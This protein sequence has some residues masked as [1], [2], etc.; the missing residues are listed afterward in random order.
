[1]RY[2]DIVK[3]VQELIKLYKAGEDGRNS[4]RAKELC[5]LLAKEKW[6]DVSKATL[7]ARM[8]SGVLP[9]NL[10]TTITA[11]IESFRKQQDTPNTPVKRNDNKEIKDI[12]QNLADIYSDFLHSTDY[13]T[14][15][16]R[17]LSEMYQVFNKLSDAERQNLS[18][19]IA[20]EI[21]PSATARTGTPGFIDG[22]D[23]LSWGFKIQGY[24]AKYENKTLLQDE[25]QQPSSKKADN[26]RDKSSL[27]NGQ[28]T[29]LAS[30]AE[31]ASAMGIDLTT[32]TRENYNDTVKNLETEQEKAI[33]RDLHD[34]LTGKTDDYSGRVADYLEAAGLSPSKQRYH[35]TKTLSIL[36]SEFAARPQNK[37]ERINRDRL[38]GMALNAYQ[39][40]II[41]STS[42]PKVPE[43]RVAD[44]TESLLEQMAKV[45]R[46]DYKKRLENNK[47]RALP[48]DQFLADLK[49][50]TRSDS[51]F[52]PLTNKIAANHV[53]KMLEQLEPQAQDKYI[54]SLR[55]NDLAEY[56]PEGYTPHKNERDTTLQD[57]AFRPTAIQKKACEI[58]GLNWKDYQNAD[59]LISALQGAGYIIDGK[60][61]IDL[62][63]NGD[64][65][66]GKPQEQEDQH[67]N[68]ANPHKKGDRTMAEENNK[69]TVEEVYKTLGIENKDNITQLKDI[70][71][72]IWDKYLATNPP[73]DKYFEALE[74]HA[75]HTDNFSLAYN[76]PAIIK[77]AKDYP[78]EKEH[79]AELMQKM[80]ETMAKDSDNPVRNAQIY[81]IIQK[82]HPELLDINEDTKE[83]LNTFEGFVAK[84]IEKANKKDYETK[85]SR[86][87]DYAVEHLDMEAFEQK[88]SERSATGE[89]TFTPSNIQQKACEY[90][91]IDWK[92]FNDSDSINKAIEGAGLVISGANIIDLHME[93][94][95][96][97]VEP[98]TEEQKKA[99]EEFQKN[100]EFT[101]RDEGID[102]PLPEKEDLTVKPLDE[103]Q[104]PTNE[105]SHEQPTP[106]PVAETTNDD[107][108]A[109]KA[110]YYK[111]LSENNQIN[112]YERD[113][114]V[115][116]GFAASF[117]EA[118]I[119]YSSP[120]NVAVSKEAGLNVFDAML[121]EPDN[122]GRR[123]NFSA[124]MPPE[125][126]ARLYAACLINGNEM[127][128][129]VPQLTEE[130]LR[131]A[132]GDEYAVFQQK[133]A[134]RQ[135]ERQG[136]ER[137][138]DQ[139]APEAPTQE[140]P[141]PETPTQEGSSQEPPATEK[142]TG[143]EPTLDTLKDKNIE[144]SRDKN[145]STQ[146]D[147][148]AKDE[149][150]N[151]TFEFHGELKNFYQTKGEYSA[152]SGEEFFD[153]KGGEKQPLPEDDRK[154]IAEKINDFM[155]KE[156]LMD[157]YKMAQ[158]EA[159]G[160]I[161]KSQAGN[162]D[163]A[164]AYTLKT[165]KCTDEEFAE[166]RAMEAR[167]AYGK[168]FLAKEFEKDPSRVREVA[169]NIIR[170][171]A[172]GKEASVSTNDVRTA[173]IKALREK[174]A[175]TKTADGNSDALLDH[176]KKILALSGRLPEGEKA[177]ITKGGEKQEV[178]A[179]EGDA[180][181][182]FEARNKDAIDRALKNYQSRGNR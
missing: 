14:R 152:K 7:K 39:S 85:Y 91:G 138:A 2:E 64:T 24:L 71:F 166:Y 167:A 123:V 45:G 182:K 29:V 13:D 115:Q 154:F 76:I 180:K 140:T 22:S 130:Q 55:K 12:Y 82:T 48:K 74:T 44:R 83:V 105:E 129:S 96:A 30:L 139:P 9:K 69:L 132:L 164:T 4:D 170:D 176:D 153:N 40:S 93:A 106:A 118:K 60:N 59:S 58:A 134:E 79:M 77:A 108:I 10:I 158:M 88:H 99:A 144:I 117:N 51:D 148:V 141:T 97:T 177:Y 181:T 95:V 35:W 169:G 34:Y 27:S 136:T 92:Q 179:L 120:N 143:P 156:A 146:I 5:E 163:S 121:K 23:P 161:I 150:G 174:M 111:G 107:W 122:Q 112:N 80:C 114:T 54:N 68:G 36:R 47:G 65:P 162:G 98:E 63:T 56:I 62:N 157:Q 126:A 171:I 3:S 135:A 173:Q 50:N 66:R 149:N 43:P 8:T 89:K 160:K 38:M 125:M 87:V 42:N 33:T 128:G 178:K 116:D 119:H 84:D 52:I 78:E 102:L 124:D 90:A 19:F 16:K 137:T 57:N 61:I 17:M 75:S 113:E 32:I 53:Q 172:A 20:N 100:K 46:S 70:Q 37:E 49:K 133:M 147:L 145:S 104:Q 15:E 11:D 41:K 21:I 25:S 101:E 127:G 151:I 73:K 26:K 6:N 94:V 86:L 131:T 72:D 18:T 159:S 103:T 109:R 175:Q 155:L 168:S 67:Q 165:N 1:M 31:Y 81:G 142:K 28:Q 110:A